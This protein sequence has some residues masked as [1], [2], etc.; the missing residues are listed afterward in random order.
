MDEIL[1]GEKKYVS[2]KQAAKVTGYAKDYIGQLCREGRV[3][4]RLVGR[5]WYV[6][7][8]AIHDHRFGNPEPAKEGKST[9]SLH[10]TW[11]APRYEASKTEVLPSVSRSQD[12]EHQA[13]VEEKTGNPDT[14][15]H[16]QDA[17]QSWFNRFDQV[18]DTPAHEPV[19]TEEPT[20]EPKEIEVEQE[21][22]PEQE[23]SVQIP[24]RTVYQPHYQSSPEEPL[25]REVDVQ[26]MSI[27]RESRRVGTG[28]GLLRTMQLAGAIVAVLS[29]SAAVLGSGYLDSYAISNSQVRA[30]A[31][32]ALYN[33]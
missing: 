13:L 23:Q 12:K 30:I 14:A 22:E 20:Q 21:P 19:A 7:E 1:I 15:Q 29:A 32:V 26:P 27:V 16:L 33:R 24:I 6:L 25:P 9:S 2:S 28:R 31:G 11:E 5:S 10:S 8:S 4:A 17:W 18:A 3:P